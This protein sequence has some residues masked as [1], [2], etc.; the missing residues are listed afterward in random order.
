MPFFFEIGSYANAPGDRSCTATSRASSPAIPTAGILGGAYLFKMWGLPAAAL[1][2]W[3]CARPENRDKVGGIM[4]S[5]ALTSFL[6][7][8]HRADRVLVPVRG[9]G[10]LRAPRAAGGRRPVLVQ[11]ARRPKLGFTFS[12][13]VIDYVLFYA[14]DTKPWLV[15]VF[16]PIWALVYYGTFRWAIQRFDLKTPGRE[17][18]DAAEPS[19]G[20]DA[21]ASA[22]QVRAGARAGLRRARQHQEPRRLHHAAARRGREDV[23]APTRRGSRRS[24]AAGVVVVGQNVQA[25]FGT[26]SE[27][28]KTDM[29]EY[30]RGAASAVSVGDGCAADILKALGGAANV[31]EIQACAVTRLRVVVADESRVNEDALRSA[32]VPA[33]MRLPG[34]T[35]HLVVGGQAEDLASAILRSLRL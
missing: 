9:A 17:L 3:R 24:G 32:G 21:A 5:A 6:T 4:I 26:R 28:L 34:R 14:I 16:G 30:L 8:H 2:M 12:H 20:A 31:S 22:E 23:A 1:A 25:I 33:L 7:G 27:N 11:P 19:A 18:E 13:G 10:A 29:E 15:L 35:L